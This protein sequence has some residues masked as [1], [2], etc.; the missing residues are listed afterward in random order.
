MNILKIS[1]HS[2][3]IVL[4]LI[5]I[6][7]LIREVELKKFYSVKPNGEHGVKNSGSRQ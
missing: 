5:Y 7:P 1:G 2:R 6:P 4:S 3:K